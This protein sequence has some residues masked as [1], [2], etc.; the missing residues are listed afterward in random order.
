MRTSH[1]YRQYLRGAKELQP[2]WKRC[3]QYV[4][5]DLGEALGQ[6]YV[7]KTF[8]P[9]TKAATVEMTRQIEDAMALRIQQLDWMSPQPSSRRWPSSTPFATRSA[10]PTSGAT[11]AR[12]RLSADDFYGNGLRATE[13]ETHRADSTRSASRSTATNGA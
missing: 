7:R 11:T 5:D 13:F 2:R 4:D 6:V 12:S 9:E 10:I 3:V 1:F 8:S